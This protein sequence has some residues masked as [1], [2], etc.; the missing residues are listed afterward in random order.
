MDTDTDPRSGARRPRQAKTEA[1][2]AKRARQLLTRCATEIARPEQRHA[3]T[4]AEFVTWLLALRPGVVATSWQQY[5]SASV[6]LLE[7]AI[8]LKTAALAAVSESGEM[9]ALATSLATMQTALRDLQAAGTEGCLRTTRRTSSRKAKLFDEA[10]RHAIVAEAERI[11]SRYAGDL[12]DCLLAAK[13]CGLRPAEWAGTRL[14]P[15][16]DPAVLVLRVPNA[17]AD[18]VR[19]HG[20]ART[21]VFERLPEVERRAVERWVRRISDPTLDAPRL[22]KALGDCLHGITRALWPRRTKHITLYSARHEF[23]ALAKVRY[24][25]AEVAALMGHAS[26]VTATDHYGRYRAGALPPGLQTL[27]DRLPKPDPSEILRVR[28]KLSV[29]LDRLPGLREAPVA[30][31]SNVRPNV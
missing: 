17:K 14:V 21:L 24:R 1:D 3:V 28:R 18:T 2:Y 10:D 15:S 13:R 6:F 16:D 30:P 23:A 29:K 25:P 19:A 7:R 5:K 12:A 27:L 9:R 31:G 20:P 11:H 26:D 22:I 8:D 4:W